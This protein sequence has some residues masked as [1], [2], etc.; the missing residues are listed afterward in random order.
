MNVEAPVRTCFVTHIFQWR[1]WKRLKSLRESVSDGIIP[2]ALSFTSS[3]SAGGM[4]WERGPGSPSS[5][6]G[7]DTGLGGSVSAP[8]AIAER[9]RVER[10]PR[11]GFARTT[12]QKEWQLQA[13]VKYDNME[14]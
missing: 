14:R 1:K 5:A 8:K 13:V 12:L 2:G 6:R 11:S 10:G 7:R 4:R 3:F 9:P